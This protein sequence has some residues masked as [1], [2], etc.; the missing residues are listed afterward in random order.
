[1]NGI[2]DRRPKAQRRIAPIPITDVASTPLPQPP[3]INSL[4]AISP[5]DQ[6][7]GQSTLSSPP[8]L[9]EA[10]IQDDIREDGEDSESGSDGVELKV[11]AQLDDNFTI[12][13]EDDEDDDDFNYRPDPRYMEDEDYEFQKGREAEIP[14]DELNDLKRLTN[15]S[16]RKRPKAYKP[17][18]LDQ[19]VL[20]AQKQSSPLT[21][22]PP[23][24]PFVPNTL[25]LGEIRIIVSQMHSLVYLLLREEVYWKTMKEEKDQMKKSEEEGR[26]AYLQSQLLTTE[27]SSS[28]DSFI[29]PMERP[30]EEKEDERN[31]SEEKMAE[32][33]IDRMVDIVDKMAEL[34]SGMIGVVHQTDYGQQA[35]SPENPHYDIFTQ[36][37]VQLLQ[38]YKLPSKQIA[39]SL[40]LNAPVNSFSSYDP[41]FPHRF[42]R[43]VMFSPSED[44]LLLWGLLR[45][46]H[47]FEHVQQAYFPHRTIDTLRNRYYSN[48]RTNE[49]MYLAYSLRRKKNKKS[50]KTAL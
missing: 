49:S 50:D 28:P 8:S 40:Q 24:T 46:H 4:V 25:S 34:L 31:P 32:E 12:L 20:S 36:L 33:S 42:D 3:P 44:I 38:E 39:Q 29:N 15:Y 13:N 43:R 22:L 5:Q 27:A 6:Y 11:L 23:P 30:Q 19:T 9:G 14:K 16:F 48:V 37:P 45:T 21:V 35:T 7:R 2:I 41:L 26:H 10:D 47:N 18:T 1:M 17:R